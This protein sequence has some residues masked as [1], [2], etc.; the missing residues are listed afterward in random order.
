VSSRRVSKQRKDRRKRKGG[1][2]DRGVGG[3]NGKERSQQRRRQREIYSPEAGREREWRGGESERK[4]D[5]RGRP[6]GS[7]PRSLSLGISR[8]DLQDQVLEIVG[9]LLLRFHQRRVSEGGNATLTA[10][11]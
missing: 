11:R 2:T 1:G 8:Q 4:E 3:V 10:P 7:L 6:C 9:D 5:R